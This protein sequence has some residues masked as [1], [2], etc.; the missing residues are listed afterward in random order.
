MPELRALLEWADTELIGR[1]TFINAGNA[2]P[3][4]PAA[5]PVGIEAEVHMCNAFQ[6]NNVEQ[7][8]VE[9]LKGHAAAAHDEQ[10]MSNAQ[11][12]RQ[13]WRALRAP[14]RQSASTVPS[15]RS[16]KHSRFMFVC[17]CDTK[18]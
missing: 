6:P 17:A 11:T 4:V 18:E 2:S 15:C 9:A 14:T 3:A 12:W 10:S 5:G 16:I 8:R 7:R 1:H 13:G